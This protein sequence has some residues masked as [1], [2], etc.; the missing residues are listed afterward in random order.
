MLKDISMRQS[1]ETEILTPR[2]VS[3]QIPPKPQYQ[4]IGA[5]KKKVTIAKVFD[6]EL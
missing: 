1:L 5:K 2:W 4:S 6:I 3:F